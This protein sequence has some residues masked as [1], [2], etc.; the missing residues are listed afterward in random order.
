MGPRAGFDNG[1]AGGC[2]LFVG[3]TWLISESSYERI[4]HLLPM[5]AR[6]G[7]F[8]EGVWY[9]R[10]PITGPCPNTRDTVA[11]LE[12]DSGFVLFVFGVLTSFLR[13]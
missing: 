9:F 8:H 1:M 2:T 4:H 10:L 11:M 13:Y 5:P 12:F 3:L 7:R 6:M